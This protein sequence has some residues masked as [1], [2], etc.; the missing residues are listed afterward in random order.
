MMEID[1]VVSKAVFERNSYRTSGSKIN[2]QLWLSKC[3]TW[4]PE[5]SVLPDD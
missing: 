4:K 1:T 5:L 3:F 2:T